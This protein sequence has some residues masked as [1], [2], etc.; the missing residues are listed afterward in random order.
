MKDRVA[1]KPNR[2]KLTFEDPSLGDKWATLSLDDEP[3]EVGT[4]LNSATLCNG[5]LLESLGLAENATPTEAMTAIRDFNTVQ[6]YKGQIINGVDDTVEGFG[7]VTV[8]RLSA[9]LYELHVECKI[10][11]AS[12]SSDNFSWGI[13]R[14]F[15][16]NSL[17]ILLQPIEGGNWFVTSGGF[18]AGV[19]AYGYGPCWTPINQFWVPSR[20]YT[21][22]GGVGGWSSRVI[23]LNTMISGTFYGTVIE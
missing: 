10:T 13:N 3:T 20:M 16:Y 2:F 19:D 22:E 14:D 12:S 11:K 8:K 1:T 7:I 5:I 23:S 21:V 18:L 15:I 6:T 17:Q 4:P 9:T